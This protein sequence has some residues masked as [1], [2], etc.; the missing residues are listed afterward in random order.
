MSDDARASPSLEGNDLSQFGQ[1]APRM[2][3]KETL[4]S[5]CVRGGELALLQAASG[6]DDATSIPSHHAPSGVPRSIVARR[7]T[8]EA[9]REAPSLGG[10]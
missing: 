9:G 4:N 8:A 1:V 3:F 5:L 10:R 7:G 6:G 2:F